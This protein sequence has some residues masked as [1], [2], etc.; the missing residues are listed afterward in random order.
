[1]LSKEVIT[2][3][4]DYQGYY[5][6]DLAAKNNNMELASQLIE[7]QTKLLVDFEKWK[8]YSKRCTNG[9]R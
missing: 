5:P 9:T 1:L 3:K 6:L 8:Y 2:F 7:T 4:P